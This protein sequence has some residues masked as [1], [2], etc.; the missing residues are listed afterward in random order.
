MV[1]DVDPD[2][3]DVWA[4]IGAI[5]SIAQALKLGPNG[6]WKTICEPILQ[7]ATQIQRTFRNARI[8]ANPNVTE[9]LRQEAAKMSRA[10]FLIQMTKGV[11]P[12]DTQENR[13]KILEL[14]LLSHILTAEN[15]FLGFA[16]DGTLEN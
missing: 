14:Y 9:E 1:Y 10:V 11:I 13:R 4:H 7:R 15:M 2:T 12:N 3:Q 8:K 16:M 6:S 5:P